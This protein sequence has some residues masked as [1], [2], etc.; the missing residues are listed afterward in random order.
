[1]KYYYGFIY[2][3]IFSGYLHT[4][5][6]LWNKEYKQ[7]FSVLI[8]RKHNSWRTIYFLKQADNPTKQNIH[9]TESYRK[10][11]EVSFSTQRPMLI[12]CSRQ[13]F[14]NLS[15]TILSRTAKLH[16]DTVKLVC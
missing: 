7:L 9:E 10:P 4:G 12:L 3:Q 5:F 1:M 15:N 11:Y 2:F 16:E 8:L 13:S 6:I 14:P